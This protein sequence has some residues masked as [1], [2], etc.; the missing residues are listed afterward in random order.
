MTA[1]GV[2]GLGAVDGE[3]EVT[4]PGGGTAAIIGPED[5]GTGAGGGRRA[6]TGGGG[7]GSS[8]WRRQGRVSARASR[9]TRTMTP[10][11]ASSSGRLSISPRPMQP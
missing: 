4:L 7:A 1:T 2:I 5:T 9:V 8:R 6:S 10:T 11:E 3:G